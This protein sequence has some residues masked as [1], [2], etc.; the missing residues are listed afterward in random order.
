[1]GIVDRI[2]GRTREQESSPDDQALQRYR[3]LMRTAPPEAIEE[4]HREAFA[5]LTSEQRAQVLREL[6]AAAPASERVAES[7][8][9]DPRTLARMATRAELRQPGV[10]ERTL[11][12]GPSLGGMFAGS[13]FGSIVGTVIGS[14]IA[15]QLLGGYAAPIA[16][17]GGETA[18]DEAV[19]SD[20]DQDTDL[21]GDFGDD[22]G[23][24][25]GD[26]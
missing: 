16:E 7:A 17:S 20:S 23:S 11:A 19:D 22:A 25:M 1:M 10:L 4:T 18:S 13:L 14:T 24:D 15:H 2:T 21:G 12:G 8:D 26:F 3:Y 9:A 6:N 5:R